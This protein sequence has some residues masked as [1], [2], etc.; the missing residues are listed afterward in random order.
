MKTRG[1]TIVEILIALLVLGV[2]SLLIGKFVFNQAKVSQR[3]SHA[4]SLNDLTQ[5]IQLLL[6]DGAL[7]KQTV[8]KIMLS[9]TPPQLDNIKS[10]NLEIWDTT[11]PTHD[12]MLK[13]GSPLPLA[14]WQLTA[15]SLAINKLSTDNSCST[16]AEMYLYQMDYSVEQINNPSIKKSHSL[17]F[18]L[19]TDPTHTLVAACGAS[20]DFCSNSNNNLNA[21]FEIEEAGTPL[22]FPTNSYDEAADKSS[23]MSSAP[24]T[25]AYNGSSIPI[26][27]NDKSTGDV[28]KWQWIITSNPSVATVTNDTS[29]T[30]TYSTQNASYAITRD[31]TYS[32]SLR[33]EDKWGR[34]DVSEQ[35]IITPPDQDLICKVAHLKNTSKTVI[36]EYGYYNPIDISNANGARFEHR[37]I[38]GYANNGTITNNDLKNVDLIIIG[39]QNTHPTQASW[40]L[41]RPPSNYS[42]NRINTA[43]KAGTNFIFVADNG[44]FPFH[45]TD[46]SFVT[47]RVLHHITSSIR[48]QATYNGTTDHIST[49]LEITHPSVN[50]LATFRR[51]DFLKN[52][53]GS[54]VR[55][56]FPSPG[57]SSP[58]IMTTSGAAE[59]IAR[60]PHNGSNAGSVYHCHVAFIEKTASE[61]FI[62]VS[63]NGVVGMTTFIPNLIKKTCPFIEL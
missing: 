1:F 19:G 38:N 21:S 52:A 17:I 45:G 14:G 15:N 3:I 50:S 26:Q 53:D 63:G 9:Q 49:Y 34:F 13:E 25:A 60:G 37:L 6:A 58:G 59:C 35:R 31:N 39:D 10:S 47:R 46:A 12:L 22:I 55:F 27:L 42:L 32:I 2:S 28:V 62:F 20:F 23:Y 40:G 7:C 5:K 44:F 54:Y 41:R 16:G 4:A 36:H 24:Q 30:P 61:G 29:S 43:H 57:A 56:R 48:Y 51:K 33:I 18:K 8:E 11:T